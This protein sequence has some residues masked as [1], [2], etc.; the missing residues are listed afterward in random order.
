[1]IAAKMASVFS[2]PPNFFWLRVN[3]IAGCA[4]PVSELQ[5]KGLVGV[6]VRHI[7]TLSD[8]SQPPECIR[9][10]NALKWTIIPVT[11]FKGATISQFRTFFQICQTALARDESVVVHCRGGRGRTGMFLAAYL[12]KFE[13]Q[14]AQT[15]IK[16][17]RSLQ[18]HSVETRDQELSLKHLE[19][20]IK[21][22]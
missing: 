22:N 18:P 16:V 14:D 7:I 2:L 19:N 4:Q 13:D 1:M 11:N 15:A 6:N 21:P 3:Q 10:I 8:E 5:L 17:V 9:S 20:C 12:M